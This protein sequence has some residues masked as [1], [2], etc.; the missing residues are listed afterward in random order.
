MK[1]LIVDDEHLTLKTIQRLLRRRGL[2]NCDLCDNG[3]EAISMLKKKQYDVVILDIIMPE[4]DGLRVLEVAAPMNPQTEFIV[5]TALD[6]VTHAVRAIKL[7]AYDYLV[8]PLD[9]ERL[10]LTIERAYERKGM[11]AGLGA[12]LGRDLDVPECFHDVVT[13]STRMKE[14]LVYA[15]VM[16]HSGNPILISGESGT[17]KELVVR[18]IHRASL[19]SK[20][21]FVPVN[22][23]AIPESLFESHFFGHVKGTFTGAEKDHVGYFEQAHGGTLF[24][25][26]VGELPLN[27]QPKLLRVLEDKTFT[28]LGDTKPTQVDIRIVSSTNRDLEKACREHAFRI[29]LLFRLKS[30]HIALPPL[31]DRTGDILLL[32]NHFLSQVSRE[33]GRES[34][35]FSPEAMR[36]LNSKQYP[37]N[38]R[39]LFHLVTNAAIMARGEVIQPFHLSAE[40]TALKS[41]SR[42][43]CSL[44]E[45]EDAHVIYVLNQ[46]GGNRKETA[47]ILGVSVRQIQRKVAALREDPRWREL[48]GDI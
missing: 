27:L 26:E 16:A 32:A 45:N 19:Y 48:L 4:V 35:G 14:L 17:G 40:D 33:M 46:T 7:G 10:L 30:A 22:M 13:R 31:R 41:F 36:I 25:D 42:T 28:R 20:G 18:G 34:K 38:V 37:G 24:L 21:P 15:Q 23:A 5:L 9:N 39:E 29:D 43:L 12:T 1:I 6:E 47:R 11:K 2:R 3:A 44:R 8:K